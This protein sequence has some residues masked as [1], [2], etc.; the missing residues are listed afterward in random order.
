MDRWLG[1]IAIVTGAGSGIGK[2][3][4]YALLRNGV[5]VAALD[6]QKERLTKLNEEC[7]RDR[8]LGKLHS[9][10]CDISI[11]N[12]IDEAF[13]T[14]ETLLGG[15]DI[16]VNCAGVCYFSRVIGTSRLC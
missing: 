12:E 5:N 9:I 10:C 3:I 16:M 11:E 1:K 15:V 8:T 14:V 2:A 4:T 6:I 7:K 13:S